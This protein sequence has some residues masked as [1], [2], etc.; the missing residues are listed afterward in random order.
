MLIVVKA[1]QIFGA[2]KQ[3]VRRI[4]EKGG[5]WKE[6]SGKGG[7]GG[8]GV[9]GMEWSGWVGLRGWNGEGRAV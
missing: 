6:W 1:W 2:F 9:L 4:F 8:G 5:G 7:V 3:P